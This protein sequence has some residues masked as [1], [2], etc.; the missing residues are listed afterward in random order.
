MR[1]PLRLYYGD[2]LLIDVSSKAILERLLIIEK[3][4]GLTLFDYKWVESDVDEDFFGGVLQ[5]FLHISTE[6]FRK[7]EIQEIRFEDGK[8]IIHHGENIMAGLLVTEDNDTL[9]TELGEFL[10]MF[11]TEYYSNPYSSPNEVS[12]Y[13]IVNTLVSQYFPEVGD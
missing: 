1:N 2:L 13:E 11:E 4:S 12:K 7:G 8:L 9:R 10:H 3:D 5:G 6:A